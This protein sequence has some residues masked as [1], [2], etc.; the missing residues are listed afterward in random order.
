MTRYAHDRA[1]FLLITC[2]GLSAALCFLC[3]YPASSGAG[4]LPQTHQPVWKCP[5]EI[6]PLLPDTRCILIKAKNERILWTNSSPH[7]NRSVYFTTS[8]FEKSCWDIPKD[9]GSDQTGE[10]IVQPGAMIYTI[11][12]SD[13][14]CSAN[15]KPQKNKGKASDPV[16][17][18]Q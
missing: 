15:P 5:I 7:K 13:A 18:I 16:V 11:Y 3:T 9:G 1:A 10:I 12:A 6:S 4:T 17:I 14:P 8:P 2:F